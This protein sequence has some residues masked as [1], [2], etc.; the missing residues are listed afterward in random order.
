MN[1]Q[2]G[3]VVKLHNNEHVPVSIAHNQSF[4]LHVGKSLVAISIKQKLLKFLLTSNL[5]DT[6]GSR[7][8]PKGQIRASACP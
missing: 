2:V 5:H 8:F 7:N 1:L 4:F 6:G 3:D